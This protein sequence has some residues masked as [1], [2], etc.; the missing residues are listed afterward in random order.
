[1]HLRNPT[2]IVPKA[3]FLFRPGLSALFLKHFSIF[4]PRLNVFTNRVYRPKIHQPFFALLVRAFLV[5]PAVATRP[6]RRV[7]AIH[8]SEGFVPYLATRWA[9]AG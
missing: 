1:M 9:C 4:P 5:F 6:D 8:D 2:A 3:S 7:A